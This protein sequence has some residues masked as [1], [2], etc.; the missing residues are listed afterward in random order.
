[1]C[2]II[3]YDFSTLFYNSFTLNVLCFLK[4][5]FFFVCEIDC[6]SNGLDQI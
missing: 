3:K 2:I 5:F 6:L 1:M 4:S